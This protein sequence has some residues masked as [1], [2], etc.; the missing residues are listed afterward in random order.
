M[1]KKEIIAPIII[2]LVAI[3][4]CILSKK[5]LKK[6]LKVAHKNTDGKTKTIVNLI[7]NIIK[8]I[9]I[10]IAILLIL[11][12]YGIDTKS[13]VAS[14]G[15]VGLVVG[16]ALQDILKDFISGIFIIFEGQ[17]SI[18]DWV[19]INGFLG[20]VLPSNLKTTKIRSATGEVKI[21]ANRN[22]TDLVNYSLYPQ[23]TLIDV[24]VSYDSDVDKVSNI[25]QKVCEQFKAANKIKDA[26]CLGVQKLDSSSIVYRL[27]VI[28]NYQ[29]RLDIERNLRKEILKELK[30]NKIEIPYNQL[31]I[32][33]G[34]RV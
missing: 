15:V 30:K 12:V 24:G 9:I 19:S 14:L 18:G 10:L 28:T 16:L 20:E 27:S 4:L 13:L 23:V 33:N 21:I 34:K 22:I 5:I 25:L 31:V 29:N 11:E 7:S 32:H 2:I 3:I 8:I 26:S 1:L 17:Y 6:V